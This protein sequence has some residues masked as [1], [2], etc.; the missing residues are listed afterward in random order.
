MMKR[1]VFPLVAF[2][3]LPIHA[4]AQFEDTEIVDRLIAIVGD[5]VVVQTEVEEEIQ[6]MRLGG[7]SIPTPA[8]P[9]YEALFRQVLEQFVERLLILQAAAKDSLIQTDEAIINERVTQQLEQLRQQFGGQTALQEALA[10]EALSLTEYRE[11]LANQARIQQVQQKYFQLRLRDAPPAEI[12]EDEM[13]ARFQEAQQQLGQ[14][15]RLLTFRQ[16]VVAPS[17]SDAAVEAAREEAQALLERVNAGEDFEELA[18][19]YS[20]DVGTAELGG[21]LGWFRRGT[22]VREFE[23]AAFP[24]LDGQVSDLVKTDFGYH[25]IKAAQRRAG[26]RRS[27]HILIVPAKTEADLERAR[28]VARDV[29]QRARDGE[30]MA[31]LFEEYSDPAAPDSLTL[32][33]DQVSDL[34]PV[35]SELRSASTGIFVGPLEYEVSPGETRIAVIHVIE[36]REAGAY[37]FEDLRGQIASQ[38][39]AEKQREALVEELRANTYIEIRM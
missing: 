6:R 7:T 37:T 12:T 26:E 32:P 19:E 22:M 39:Q 14:R 13:L 30:S 33:F 10:A 2:A 25:I 24:L 35:Y 3:F 17:P 15:P 28:A 9:G 27:R 21:D 31:D 29:L 8:D 36:V 5:S 4:S 11:F 20:D 34:P 16:V 18:R 1:C 38:L 23:D